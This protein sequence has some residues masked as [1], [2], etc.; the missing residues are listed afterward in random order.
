KT[1]L[2][3]FD[4]CGRQFSRR[5]NLEVHQ[6]IHDSVRERPFICQTCQ[7]AFLKSSDLQ[8]HGSVHDE[9]KQH[10]CPGQLCGKNFSR[11]DALR[12]HMK[13]SGCRDPLVAI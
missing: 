8:R 2:C 13:T 1:Y 5:F 7:R 11:Q 10:R 6:K 4:N 3:S 9:S 12:R